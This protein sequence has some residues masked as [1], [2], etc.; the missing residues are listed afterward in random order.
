M[1]KNGTKK[2]ILEFFYSLFLAKLDHFGT[3]EKKCTVIKWSSLQKRVS[4]F[5][6]K[7]LNSLEQVT[8]TERKRLCTVLH[9]LTSLDQQLL[10]LKTFTF[11]VSK[12]P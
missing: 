9:I 5:T 1:T 12:L 4:K 7:K 3:T 6:P 8:L 10:I 11:L 2:E